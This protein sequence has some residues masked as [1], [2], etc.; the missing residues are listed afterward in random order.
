MTC[1][2]E[3]STHADR[4]FA[5]LDRAIKRR[6]LAKLQFFESLPDPLFHAKKLSGIDDVYRFRIGD[7][8]IIITPERT[9]KTFVI[10][11]V[12]KIGH[13]RDVYDD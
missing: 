2:F 11:L 9:K 13:R 6:I 4:D 5:C 3:F 8:R 7:Y 10:L 1:R 12:L